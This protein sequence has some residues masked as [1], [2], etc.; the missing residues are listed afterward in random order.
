MT[1]KAFDFSAVPEFANWAREYKRTSGRDAVVVS[2]GAGWFSADTGAVPGARMRKAG[3]VEAAAR[4]AKRPDFAT[5]V[6]ANVS[7]LLDESFKVG[8]AVLVVGRICTVKVCVG[9]FGYVTSV[10]DDE[11]RVCLSLLS[12][13][14]FDSEEERR[15]ET[16]FGRFKS[17][18]ADA[19]PSDLRRLEDKDALARVESFKE[20]EAKNLMAKERDPAFEA[21]LADILSVESMEASRRMEAEVAA[22]SLR[23]GRVFTLPGQISRGD[24][25]AYPAYRTPEVK[26]ISDELM[27]YAA[28]KTNDWSLTERARWKQAREATG[29]ASFWSPHPDVRALVRELDLDPMCDM[30]ERAL[31]ENSGNVYV[32]VAGLR[33]AAVELWNSGAQIHLISDMSGPGCLW[34]AG[35]TPEPVGFLIYFASRRKLP[36]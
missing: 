12:Y 2:H 25:S 30:Y 16:E 8:D 5:P 15:A 19:K 33:K 22:E 24:K 32:P 13:P 9:L 4:L 17:W 20:A 27:G 14:S 1:K 36:V 21:I 3:F 23:I 6:V 26:A 31:W 35:R 18:S 29:C 28:R 11:D 34:E 7:D 10:F